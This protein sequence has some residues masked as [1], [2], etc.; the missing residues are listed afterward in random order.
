MPLGAP[1]RDPEGARDGQ[2]GVAPGNPLRLASILHLP[3]PA[4]SSRRHFS[5]RA[6]IPC[7]T[8]AQPR[9]TPA[10]T[11]PPAPPSVPNGSVGENCDSKIW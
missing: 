5:V 3:L 6:P 1:D 11:A 2:A 7:P 8:E 4:Y 9:V 10:D